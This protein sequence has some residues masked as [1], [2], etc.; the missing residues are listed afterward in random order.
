ME[1]VIAGFWLSSRSRC[2]S[3]ARRSY[4]DT[5]PRSTKKQERYAKSKFARFWDAFWAPADPYTTYYTP[6]FNYPSYNFSPY[7]PPV[8]KP[9]V[10]K[11]AVYKPLAYE[12]PS[13]TYPALNDPPR[14]YY[15][16]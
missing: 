13:Y 14:L 1:V 11:P 15:R 16:S 2:R 9:H 6:P 10:Y 12:T 5:D 3:N 8:Y 4:E 7:K